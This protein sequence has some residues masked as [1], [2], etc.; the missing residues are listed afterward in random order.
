MTVL[1]RWT[2]RIHKWLALVVGIQIVLWIAG[3]VVMSVIP[4]EI[5]PLRERAEDIL[6]L[7]YHMVRSETPNG[8]EPP[9]MEPEAQNILEE[10]DDKRGSH[11][12][13]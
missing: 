5:T 8:E 11:R 10:D 13:A 2:L 4:I 12:L 7:V 6:P 3:G 1:L 9:T